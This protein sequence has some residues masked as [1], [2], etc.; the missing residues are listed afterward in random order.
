MNSLHVNLKNERL[1]ES[2]CNHYIFGELDLELSRNFKRPVNIEDHSPNQFRVNKEPLF[3]E[4]GC[5]RPQHRHHLGHGTCKA[6]SGFTTLA[7][8]TAPG[9][10]IWT[11]HSNH[12]PDE[13]IL[14]PDFSGQQLPIQCLMW[15]QKLAKP[16]LWTHILAARGAG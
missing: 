12:L 7:I 3:L 4:T 9:N 14:C 15:V 13:R 10:W 1:L 16:R 11:L 5:Q 6:P 2:S 8:P